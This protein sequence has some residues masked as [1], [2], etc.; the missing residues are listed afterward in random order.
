[1]ASIC[2]SQE[3]ERVAGHRDQSAQSPASVGLLLSHAELFPDEAK[4]AELIVD[5]DALAGLASLRSGSA[6]TPGR[7]AS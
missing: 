3:F 6:S 5:G 7:S 2:N 4:R 1:M